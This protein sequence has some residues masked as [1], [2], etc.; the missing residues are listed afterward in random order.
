[1]KKVKHSWASWFEYF[2]MILII[3]FR[4]IFIA[5]LLKGDR[6]LLHKTGMGKKKKLGL[7][8]KLCHR[9]S[10]WRRTRTHSSSLCRLRAIT[11]NPCASSECL[12]STMGT[13]LFTPPR[14]PIS[15]IIQIVPSNNWHNSVFYHNAWD[16]AL[17]KK[18]ELRCICEGV[19]RQAKWLIP[20]IVKGYPELDSVAWTQMF[21]DGAI[22]RQ[23]YCRLVTFW[24]SIWRPCPRPF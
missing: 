23:V 2:E 13:V 18:P 8:L 20:L 17:L 3:Y 1:M 6:G 5:N 16:S 4:S 21:T 10:V 19:C 14:H 7:I 9:Y 22:M 12:A 24:K 15:W 11:T